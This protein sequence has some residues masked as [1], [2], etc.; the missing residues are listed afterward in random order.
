VAR[1][2]HKASNE[3]LFR[4]L[5]DGAVAG[6]RKAYAALLAQVAELAKKYVRRKMGD[7]ADADDLTQEILLSAHKALP[8]YDPARPCMPWLGAIMHYRMTDWVRTRYHAAE[9][10]ETLT[11]R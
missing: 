10:M 9:K 1:N 2:D 6:V 11:F 8:T 4:P 3:S 7:H 5:F